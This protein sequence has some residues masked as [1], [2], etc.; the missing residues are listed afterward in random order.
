MSAQGVHAQGVN[1]KVSVDIYSKVIIPIALYGSELWS[2]LTFDISAISRVQHYA[3]KRILGLPTTTRSDMAESMV[4]L[5]RLPSHIDLRKMMFLHK[6]ISLNYLSGSVSRNIFIRK[7]VL[8]INDKTHVT[9]GFI[10]DICHM[11]LKYNLH[12]IINNFLAPECYVPSTYVWKSVVK[13]SITSR[14]IQLW[15]YRTSV[16]TDFVFFRI[17]HPCIKS[18]IIYKVCNRTS[19][20]NTMFVISRL[21]SRPVTLE[22]RTYINCGEIY[23]EE[24]VHVICEVLRRQNSDRSS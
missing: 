10:P 16:D 22:N 7:P 17:L 2:N 11:M 1:P 20:R 5:Y 6:I 15:D 9:S 23:Q 24:L 18:S 21:W 3:I 19:F 12:S 4:G 14:E 8:Y 13:R